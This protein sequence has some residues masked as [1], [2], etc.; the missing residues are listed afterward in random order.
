MSD[1][2]AVFTLGTPVLEL[3]VRGSLIYLALLA[4]LRVVGQRE[5]GGLGVTD[6][7]V[8]VLAADA[9]STGLIGESTAV[10]DGLVVVATILFWSIVIDALAYRSPRFARIV[11]ARPRTLIDEGEVNRRLMLRELMTM[12]EIRSQLRLHGVE[13]LSEVH[14]AY[15]EPNGMI[16]ILRRDGGE[17]DEPARPPSA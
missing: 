17:P 4:M 15:L 2:Q 12:E 3:F 14:R 8:I 7:L 9:A 5:T 1:W 10:P 13:E 6:L 11:K 16:S